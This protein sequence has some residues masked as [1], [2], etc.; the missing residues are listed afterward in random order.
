MKQPSLDEHPALM[1]RCLYIPIP[2]H[3]AWQR[4]ATIDL[5][6][7]SKLNSSPA[8]GPQLCHPD[9]TQGACLSLLRWRTVLNAVHYNDGTAATST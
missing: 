6:R 4:L 3:K 2:L 5:C 1:I 7:A 8:G 9:G